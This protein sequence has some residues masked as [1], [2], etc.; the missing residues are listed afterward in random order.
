[1]VSSYCVK[2][3]KFAG[4]W[5]IVLGLE[6]SSSPGQ[7]KIRQWMRFWPQLRYTGWPKHSP[8]L[9]TH[10]DRYVYFFWREIINH[11]L[12]KTIAIYSRCYWSSWES[13]VVYQQALW[14]L[15][16]PEGA[17]TN[18]PS[19]GK[20][21]WYSWILPWTR[22]RRSL[23]RHGETRRFAC[24]CGGISQAGVETVNLLCATDWQQIGN[25]LATDWQQISS[26]CFY[27]LCYLI[28]VWAA[29]AILINY[30]KY[31]IMFG[32]T[33]YLLL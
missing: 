10:T 6:R 5:S 3:L 17:S 11:F 31:Y 14:I 29:V 32:L 21:D 27:V 24:W 28:K 7:M 19:L 16:L 22:E 18:P 26:W 25:R 15:L 20:N 13:S 2:L 23:C 4:S 30:D 33:N 9:S 12:T 8:G 1:M